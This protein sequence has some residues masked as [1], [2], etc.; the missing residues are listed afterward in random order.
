MV[1]LLAAMS[2]CVGGD[3][4]HATVD[5]R[6]AHFVRPLVLE[7][8]R[9]RDADDRDDPP[10]KKAACRGQIRCAGGG[11][12]PWPELLVAE[13]QLGR[14]GGAARAGAPQ[15]AVRA[16]AREPASAR[17]RDRTLLGSGVGV[18]SRAPGL[19]TRER[20]ASRGTPGAPGVGLGRSPAACRG[21]TA[22]A[23][24]SGFFDETSSFVRCH[25][26]VH[27]L[28]CHTPQTSSAQHAIG[29][30]CLPMANSNPTC[31]RAPQTQ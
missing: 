12:S 1:A 29:M 28:F 4:S 24:G 6:P 22:R 17:E 9:T 3:R 20:G 30:F 31:W 7:L 25:T 5:F 10:M 21:S 19:G 11:R 13:L 18:P 16:W 8:R 15:L 26:P 2:S 14:Q 27:A 23:S